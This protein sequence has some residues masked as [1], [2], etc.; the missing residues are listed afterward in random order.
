M[1]PLIRPAHG[2]FALFFFLTGISL[3]FFRG[4][5]ETSNELEMAHTTVG[6]VENGTFA[7]DEPIAGQEFGAHGMGVSLA[8]IPA[9]LI[10]KY[11]RGRQFLES[12]DITLFPLTNVILFA[13]L[14]VIL[15]SMLEDE[16]RW[17]AT[18]LLLTASPL[19]AEST[20]FGDA[21]L[22]AVGLAGFA[23]ILWKDSHRDEEVPIGMASL[24]GA[25]LFPLI[26][27]LSDFWQAP[28]IV[29]IAFWGW[30]IGAHRKLLSAAII[31]VAVGAALTGWQNY[32]LRANIFSGGREASAFTTPVLVGLYGLLF[33]PERGLLIFFPPIAVLIFGWS[34][35]PPRERPLATLATALMIFS[36]LFHGV[37]W[38]W[39][40]G[41]SAGPRLLLPC[42]AIAIPSI[43]SLGLQWR[44]LPSWLQTSLFAAIAW[45]IALAFVYAQYSPIEWAK[46]LF[47]FHLQENESLFL[48][49]LSLWQAWL[50]GVPLPHAGAELSY[51]AH[52]V[53]LTASLCLV[54]LPLY[55]LLLPFRGY[56]GTD[57][58]T[59]DEL[60]H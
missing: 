39:S 9:L 46:K 53:F 34:W 2:A 4:A 24:I 56:V 3:F 5:L 32:A 6:I 43:V 58:A 20:G 18:G 33:S 59:R 19:L 15:S 16:R 28:C 54:L 22:S 23:A 7:F 57:P 47:P 14:G 37:F 50:A 38:A 49:Q 35:I 45:S 40:G 25:V 26:G 8:G 27:I 52:L 21:L 44:R 48:P 17:G 13:I 29:L 11:L 36:I 30:R 51:R 31:G 41:E 1:R 60:N 10:E 12:R 42:I 55:A